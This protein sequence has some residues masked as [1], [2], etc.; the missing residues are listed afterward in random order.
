MSKSDKA[1]CLRG[2]RSYSQAR[3][4]GNLIFIAGTVSWDD[5]FKV[6]GANDFRLQMENIYRDIGRTLEHFGLD[7][8]CLIKETIYT[9]DMDM[10]LSAIDVRAA[11]LST[12][13]RPATTWIAVD[14]LV[15]LQFLVEIEAIA[16]I[17]ASDHESAKVA[18]SLPL[19]QLVLTRRN[20]ESELG[21]SHAVRAGS[22][23]FVSG[24]AS[25]DAAAQPRNPGNVAAQLTNIYDELG[26]TL[27]EYGVGFGAIA[28]ETIFTSDIAALVSAAPLRIAYFGE[29]PPPASTW[30]QVDR[31]MHP[32]LLVQVEIIAEVE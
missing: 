28:K 15:N 31:L 19:A 20:V 22:L 27:A 3:R 16:V 7:F 12:S 23:L 17:P 18:D 8:S 2:E 13:T 6:C 29:C 11:N 9:R 5:D 21:F 25:W 26:E 14:R 4:V 24:V 32:D 30:L 1:F 10:F